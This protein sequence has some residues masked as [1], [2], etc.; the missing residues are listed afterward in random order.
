M[1]I[2]GPENTTDMTAQQPTLTTQAKAN[3]VVEVGFNKMLAEGVHI[4]S[5]RDGDTGFSFL[6][7]ETHSPYVDNRPLLVAGKPETRQY[8]AV[9]FQNKGEIGNTSDPVT[10]IA[11]P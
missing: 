7:S 5:M 8:R 1:D 9:F 2:I 4:Q 3:G 11:Q 6:S 10:A